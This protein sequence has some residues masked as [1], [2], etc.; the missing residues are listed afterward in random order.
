MDYSWEILFNQAAQIAFALTRK[1]LPY[2]IGR[3]RAAAGSNEGV[4][5]AEKEIFRGMELVQ[6]LRNMKATRQ[7]RSLVPTA[8][9]E[10]GPFSV[11]SFDVFILQIGDSTCSRWLVA[12]LSR[13]RA[14]EQNIIA[15]RTLDLVDSVLNLSSHVGARLFTHRNQ[16]PSPPAGPPLASSQRDRSAERLSK[17]KERPSDCGLIA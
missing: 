4:D 12:G 6:R 8:R 10:L 16:H 7:M 9:G 2:R 5:T 15:S 3:F 14:T 11:R 1:Q 13:N 17:R